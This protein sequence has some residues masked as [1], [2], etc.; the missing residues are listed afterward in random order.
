MN[1]QNSTPKEDWDAE[2]D[3]YICPGG[4]ELKQFRRKY[5]DSNRGPTGKGTA[6]CCALKD[7]CQ[8]CPSKRKCCP[9]ADAHKITREEREDARQ[10][11]RDLVKTSAN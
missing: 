11:A 5:S 10:V 3:Q 2:I 8:A 7:V 6:R 4:H 9:N 1:K